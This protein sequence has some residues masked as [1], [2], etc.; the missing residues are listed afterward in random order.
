MEP[1]V[2]CYHNHLA[3]YIA[4]HMLEGVVVAR[5]KPSSLYVLQLLLKVQQCVECK[6]LHNIIHFLS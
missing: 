2:N 5:L 6:V 4:Q 1:Y 3:I